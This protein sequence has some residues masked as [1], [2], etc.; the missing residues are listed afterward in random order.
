[1]FL[2]T[3]TQGVPRFYQNKKRT[4]FL[5]DIW[6]VRLLLCSGVKEAREMTIFKSLSVFCS[7]AK[8]RMGALGKRILISHFFVHLSLHNFEWEQCPLTSIIRGLSGSSRQAQQWEKYAQ[9]CLEQN[10]WT[11]QI[12]G[13]MEKRLSLL[14][15]SQG[16]GQ[17]FHFIC[18]L[19]FEK[20]PLQTFITTK[21]DMWVR[22]KHQKY[23]VK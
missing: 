23:Y 19:A 14:A 17:T 15:F 13:Q 10:L 11:A 20:V 7:D 3:I 4:F 18:S 6:V 22:T 9:S 5:L 21:R 2:D 12:S 1:M 16:L 8:L